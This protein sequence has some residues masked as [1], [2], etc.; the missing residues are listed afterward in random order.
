MSEIDRWMLQ[1]LAASLCTI[2]SIC[3]LSTVKAISKNRCQ[4][5][6]AEL[7]DRKEERRF[8]RSQPRSET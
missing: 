7:E 8:Q 6:L 2:I 1:F 5:R 3:L 4:V